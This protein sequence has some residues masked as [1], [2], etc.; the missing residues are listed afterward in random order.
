MIS[1]AIL[2][3]DVASTKILFTC[4]PNSKFTLCDFRCSTMGNTKDSYWLY[5]VNFKAL[6]SAKPPIW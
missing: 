3:D 4:T 5:L 2:V 6:K 1:L